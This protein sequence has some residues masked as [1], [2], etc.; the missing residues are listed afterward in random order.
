MIILKKGA[1]GLLTK[2]DTEKS[3]LSRVFFESTFVRIPSATFL[4]KNV[5]P[6]SGIKH[7]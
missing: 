6:T 5:T 2:T 1:L 4:E 3:T 7:Y